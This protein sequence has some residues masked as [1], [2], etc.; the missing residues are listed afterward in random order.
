MQGSLQA[1]TESSMEDQQTFYQKVLHPN[2]PFIHS[3]IFFLGYNHPFYP[4]DLLI[5]L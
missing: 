5:N 1:A 4:L 2:C 3:S